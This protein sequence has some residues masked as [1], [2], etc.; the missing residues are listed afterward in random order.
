MCKQRNLLKYYNL[1]LQLT[2]PG[3]IYSNFFSKV[4][5]DMIEWLVFVPYP[6]LSPIVVQNLSGVELVMLSVTL[7]YLVHTLNQ[8]V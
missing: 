8:P 4:F 3:K 1:Q 6:P 5:P 7:R 2:K